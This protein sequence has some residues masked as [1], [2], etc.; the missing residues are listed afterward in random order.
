MAERGFRSTH[1]EASGAAYPAIYPGESNLGAAYSGTLAILSRCCLA[2]LAGQFLFLLLG[3]AIYA[4]D[5]CPS[6]NG[7][8]VPGAETTATSLD[9]FRARYR[10]HLDDPPYH[11]FLTRTPVFA[12]WDDHELVNDTWRTGAL[13][14]GED[15]AQIATAQVGH[16]PSGARRRPIMA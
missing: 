14:H 5:T 4:D 12:V 16:D 11:T 13:E 2:A 15:R 1:Y 6:A 10:Y 9:G 7:N 8:N 3:D